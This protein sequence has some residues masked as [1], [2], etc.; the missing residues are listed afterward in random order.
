MKQHARQVVAPSIASERLAVLLVTLGRRCAVKVA[1]GVRA[2]ELAIQFMREPGQRMPI[3][4]VIGCESPRDAMQRQPALHLG[5][6]KDVV[7]VVDVDKPI[8]GGLAEDE[9]HRQQKK[10]AH[11]RR[12]AGV[13][14]ASVRF[15]GERSRSVVS[16]RSV[17]VGPTTHQVAL[18][19]QCAY[20]S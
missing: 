19:R 12:R 2:V 10:H 13:A 9:H 1:V 5:I 6:P 16:R 18:Q 11:G 4:G 15:G 8:P 17:F 3:G 7:L 14:R 20:T